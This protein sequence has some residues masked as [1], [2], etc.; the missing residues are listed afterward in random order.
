MGIAPKFATSENQM[1]AHT[2][3]LTGQLWKFRKYSVKS[4]GCQKLLTYPPLWSGG[5][6]GPFSNNEHIFFADPVNAI[7]APEIIPFSFASS[8]Q[9]VDSYAILIRRDKHG[10]F[11]YAIVQQR[12]I[13]GQ[14][15]HTILNSV[16]I[17]I[18]SFRYFPSSPIISN[19]VTYNISSHAS[20]FR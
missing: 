9:A 5:G 8:T 20:S 19:I 1:V 14:L 16:A 13:D 7:Y 12:S 18:Q 15:K 11:I 6:L 3:T 4:D 17:A 10:D 2:S